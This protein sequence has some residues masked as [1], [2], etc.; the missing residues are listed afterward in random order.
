[1][2]GMPSF[3]GP[4]GTM[5]SGSTRGLGVAPP[6]PESREAPAAAS[7]DR[8]LEH[9]AKTRAEATPR[10]ASLTCIRFIG[11]AS[12]PLRR[13][14]PGPLGRFRVARGVATEGQ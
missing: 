6:R 12:T 13:W 10:A 11:R 1:M 14:T 2:G 5:R 4:P 3:G 9:A 7:D 8:A